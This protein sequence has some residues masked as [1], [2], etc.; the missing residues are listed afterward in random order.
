MDIA[1][2]A[3]E[4]EA[5]VTSV[6]EYYTTLIDL[7]YLDN[8][9]AVDLL[10]LL[11]WVTL[12]ARRKAHDEGLPVTQ[13]S[14]AVT[15]YEAEVERGFIPEVRRYGYDE[16]GEEVLLPVWAVLV[17]VARVRDYTSLIYDLS[18]KTI[19]GL[20]RGEASV[21]EL[22]RSAR[23]AAELFARLSKDLRS[24]E[25]VP[26]RTNEAPKGFSK[27][28]RVYEQKLSDPNSLAR[29]AQLDFL[30]TPPCG[31]GPNDVIAGS[32]AAAE[33]LA[34][35]VNK[36]RH[37]E[38][39]SHRIIFEASGWPNSFDRQTCQQKI[40]EWEAGVH[41]IR[42]QSMITRSFGMMMVGDL[43]NGATLHDFYKRGP[44]HHAV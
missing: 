16:A 24:L 36:S 27:R 44:G 12:A 33:Q 14:T 11:P 19:S 25:V 5:L 1:S 42:M 38:F 35:A 7:A 43:E 20:S 22:E 15:Y 6:Y 34:T 37:N 10:H 41:A 40:D 3:A 30:S 4:H 9:D 8:R 29:A 13:M 17:T 21:T 31:G 23:P 32:R 18:H 2:L 28:T 26:W 39:W